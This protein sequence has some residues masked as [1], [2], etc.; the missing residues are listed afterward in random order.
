MLFAFG[1]KCRVASFVAVLGAGLVV[2]EVLA[3]EEPAANGLPRMTSGVTDFIL[4]YIDSDAPKRPEA[5]SEYWIGINGNPLDE[6]LRSQLALEEGRGLLVTEI[7]DG[8][9][10]AKMGLKVYDVLVSA[11]DKPLRETADLATLI[12][13]SKGAKLTIALIRGG[14]PVIVPVTPER[15]PPSQTGETCPSISK[16]TDDVFLRRVYLDLVGHPP[17]EEKV[18]LFLGDKA[19]DKRT[20]LVNRLLRQSTTATRSCAQCHGGD[21][22]SLSE[23]ALR[24]S[25]TDAIAQWKPYENLNFT[26]L[27]IT[28]PG[29]VLTGKDALSI[30]TKFTL[31]DDVSIM[32]THTSQQPA[33]ISVR[34]GTR[35]YEATE[36][37][38][39]E[40]LPEELRASVD[41]A[42]HGGLIRG[43]T[44]L[45]IIRLG[46]QVQ[47]GAALL[48]K[49]LTA[50]VPPASGTEAAVPKA[51]DALD[52]LLKQFDA[53]NSQMAELRQAIRALQDARPGAPGAKPEPGS[54]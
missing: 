45:D 25:L 53:M 22:K 35:T 32:I 20:S 2:G 37:D 4:S 3:A 16:V 54:K 43:T 1:N 50:P 39:R 48:E 8:S 51:D 52:R 12:E 41:A 11:G 14:K 6:A 18:K 24:S 27:L 44:G 36:A 10:A 13:G 33:K 38:Y 34:T 21:V 49:T 30:D 7:V 31:P 46:I 5:A 40:K 26:E 29:I 47:P 42:L 23:H 9:P 15:R 28:Q 17:D 19:A